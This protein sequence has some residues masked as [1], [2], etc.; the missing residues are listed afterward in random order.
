M[1]SWVEKCEQSWAA[2]NHL[3]NE[4]LERGEGETYKRALGEQAPSAGKR[5]APVA[6]A[7]AATHFVGLNRHQRRAM[8]AVGGIKPVVH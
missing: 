6:E 1:L 7:P 4:V 2:W 8:A 3:M 5:R